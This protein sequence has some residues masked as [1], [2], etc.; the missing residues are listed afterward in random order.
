[1][2]RETE[3]KSIDLRDV[4]LGLQRE[5]I[6]AL[7]TNRTAIQHPGTKGVATEAQWLAMLEH[8]LPRRYCATS[9]FVVDVEGCVSDQIDIV[10]YDQH[11]S[12]F[13]FNRDGAKYVPAESVYGVFEVKPSL[14][15]ANVAYASAKAASVR[16]LRRT[17][18][19]IVHA[20]GKYEPKIPPRILAGL[21]ASEAEW[22]PAFGDPLREALTTVAPDEQLDLVCV[23]QEGSFS[24]SYSG[25]ATEI[26]TC[27]PD[28][29]LIFFFLRLLARLQSVGTVAA[30]DLDEYSRIL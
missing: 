1:M 5:M 10:I 25:A 17:S 14:N 18:A 21:L 3:H 7:A 20:G 22:K 2:T 9:A 13:L 12:P 26:E 11:Y 27:A 15:A 24:A 6:A 16:T 4:F 28:V 30:M 8:Y 23:L 19:P 29:A